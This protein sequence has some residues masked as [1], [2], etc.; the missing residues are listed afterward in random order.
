MPI[1]EILT[2]AAQYVHLIS[3]GLL[4]LA[5]FSLPISEDLVIILSASIAATIVPEKTAYIFIGCFAGAYIS[6]VIAYLIGRYLLGDTLLKHE[7]LAKLKI[8]KLL[9]HGFS[10]KRLEK[11]KNYFD[12]YGAKTLFFGRFVPFGVRNILFMTC[13]LTHMKLKVFLIVDI[14]ALICTTIV[15]F[16]LGYTL[17]E[18]YEQIFPYLDHYKIVI[19]ALFILFLLI[20]NRK[21]LLNLITRKK[22]KSV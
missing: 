15:L 19:F 21:Q 11:L 16:S 20:F 9:K 6:D 1:T 4:F 17:G 10:E 14:C 5:G 22:A 12:K 13:G 3:F 7:R 2:D 18:N 8:I